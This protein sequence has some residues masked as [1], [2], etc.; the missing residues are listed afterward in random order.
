MVSYGNVRWLAG[1]QFAQ[2]LLLP[3]SLAPRIVIRPHTSWTT[4]AIAADSVRCHSDLQRPA[5]L[6]LL[7]HQL[8]SIPVNPRELHLM[9]EPAED[10]AWRTAGCTCRAAKREARGTT[11]VEASIGRSGGCG[12]GLLSFGSGQLANRTRMLPIVQGAVTG[13]IG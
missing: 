1:Q 3:Q 2:E 10:R 9:R 4:S 8:P 12:G 7:A 6:L 5:P 13:E 11:T